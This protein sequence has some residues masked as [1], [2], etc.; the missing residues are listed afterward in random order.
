MHH[1]GH[2]GLAAAFQTGLD[3]CLSLGADIIVTTDGD[4][5]YA[6]ADIER[7]IA[8]ILEG[9]ADIVVGDR[10]VSAAKHF[11][12]GKRQLQTIGSAVVRL[13]SG[14]AIPDA[15]SGFRAF[16]RTAA[17]QI[18]V[19]SSYSHTTET[20]MLAGVHGLRV[21]SV[22]VASRPVQRPSRLFRSTTGFLWRTGRT[23]VRSTLVNRPALVVAVLSGLLVLAGIVVRA[24]D[25]C[26]IV[27]RMK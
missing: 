8:P 4:G 24:G 27:Q 16:S 11:A 23:L 7:L 15:V 22:P 6:G 2:R 12:V 25:R 17:S 14:M 13:L 18:N 19:L 10:R 20:L 1:A 9:R 5:Q 21:A 3:A 26:S